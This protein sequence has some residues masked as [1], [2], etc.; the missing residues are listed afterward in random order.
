MILSQPKFGCLT[1]PIAF[2]RESYQTTTFT[3]KDNLKF[4][5]LDGIQSFKGVITSEVQHNVLRPYVIDNVLEVITP[6]TELVNQILSGLQRIQSNIKYFC[7]GSSLLSS[8]A[9]IAIYSM[10]LNPFL[11]CIPVVAGVGCL[12]FGLR[13]Y[14]PVAVQLKLWQRSHV[15]HFC[16]LRQMIPRLSLNQICHREYL[17]Q[18]FSAY[19]GFKLWENKALISKKDALMYL[20]KS[21]EEKMKLAHDIFSPVRSPFS[22][23][24]ITYFGIDKNP[25]LQT[26]FAEYNR[27]QENYNEIQVKIAYILEQSKIEKKKTEQSLMVEASDEPHITPMMVAGSFGSVKF[28]REMNK[29]N[30]NY[31]TSVQYIQLVRE[32]EITKLLAQLKELLID[33]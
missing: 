2:R 32:F 26:F 1:V 29:V 31:E 10:G 7:I 19:E 13:K 33:Q 6:H 28:H 27:L 12:Y 3:L 8:S 11:I 21:S 23:K 15:D 24:I 22:Q 30:E 17:G 5:P 16:Q 14:H 18:F 25:A 9:S 20:T 4:E